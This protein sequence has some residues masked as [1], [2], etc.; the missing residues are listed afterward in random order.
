MHLLECVCACVRAC[1]HMWVN[2]THEHDP[3]TWPRP[4]WVTPG[5]CFTKEQLCPTEKVLSMTDDWLH[6]SEIEAPREREEMGHWWWDGEEEYFRQLVNT[7]M[8]FGGRLFPWNPIQFLRSRGNWIGIPGICLL[9]FWNFDRTV[10]VRI[11][12]ASQFCFIAPSP[13]NEIQFSSIAYR[14]IGGGGD[15]VHKSFF[16]AMLY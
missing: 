14:Y 3:W 11:L 7:W 5:P 8:A 4:W 10:I 16:S 1:A 13:H 12:L 6:L 2:F 15:D 9:L